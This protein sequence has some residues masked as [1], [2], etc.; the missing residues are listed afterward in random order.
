MGERLP[1]PTPTSM[2]THLDSVI[3]QKLKAFARRRRSL[4]I[5]RGGLT[6]AAVLIAAMLL[7]AA[8]DYYVPFLPDAV[9]W[10]LSFT[11]YA[12]SFAVAWCYCLRPLLHAPTERQMAR[13][14][15][16]AEPKLR[17]D[18]LSAVELG[19]TRGGV[20]DSEQFRKLLQQDVS[21]RMQDIEVESLLPV[22]LIKRYIQVAAGIAAAVVALMF[23][24]QM[25]LSTLLLRAFAPGA[26]VA[27]V[28]NTRIIVVE[29][30]AGDRVVAQG[31]VVSLKIRLEG[32]V[33]GK[34]SLEAVPAGEVRAISEMK[35]VGRNEFT[36]TIKVGRGNVTYRVQAGDGLTRSYVLSAAARPI[37]TAFEKTYHYPV[38]S[39]Q[40]V[41][42]VTEPGGKLSAL[43]GTEVE[44]KITTN[45]PVKKGEL[46]LDVGSTK[47]T[48]PLVVLPD[49]RLTA[50]VPIK[51][52]GTYR[53]HLTSAETGFDNKFSPEYELRSEPDLL[54]AITLVEPE[55][56]LIS[57][58]NELV[59]VIAT[60]S[61]DVGL[62]QVAQMIK[63][64]DG[65]WKEVV[66]QKNAGREKRIVRDWDMFEEG[67]K[68]GDL[69][70]TKLVATDFAGHQ[71]DSRTLQ[72]TVVAAG[73]EMK[74]LGSL[75]NCEALLAALNALVAATDAVEK[76]GGLADEKFDETEADAP[77]GKKMLGGLAK[78]YEEFEAKL[79]ETWLA[80]NIPLRE[81]PANHQSADLVLL[82][83]M[84]VQ[85]NSAEAQ[86][87][88]PV[89][90]LLTAKPD[91]LGAPNLMRQ[92]VTAVTRLKALARIAQETTHLTLA[93]EELDVAA[94]LGLVLGAEQKRIIEKARTAKTPE[95]W[96]KLDT[97]FRTVLSTSKN[98]EGVLDQLATRGT[99][100]GDA[101]RRLADTLIHERETIEP[102]LEAG[103][104]D[105]ALLPLLERYEAALRTHTAKSFE[106]RTEL[107]PKLITTRLRLP[108]EP[109]KM[110]PGLVAV[111]H[112]DLME[113]L[114][115]IAMNIA[116]LRQ[117][118]AAIGKMSALSAEE[119]AALVLAGWNSRADIFKTH[120]DLE[121]F[122]AVADTA[123]VGDL[124]RATVALPLL[125]TLPAA[126][127]EAT[128]EEMNQSL[129]I[130]A[131]GHSLQELT[132]GLMGLAARER[133]E[134]RAPQ[135]RTGAA[136]DWAWIATR[137]HLAPE[138][139]K[140]LDLKDQAARAA[141]ESVA[142]LLTDM[143]GSAPFLKAAA[144]MATRGKLDRAPQSV[145]GEVEMLA[146]KL[147]MMLAVLRQP[148]DAARRDLGKL[149]P[150]ISE[151][152]LA[153]AKEEA[154]LKT[155]TAG[156]AEQALQAT[157]EANRTR[158]APQIAEQHQINL[159][160][161]TL[162]DLIRADANEQNILKKDQRERMR[163]ANDAIALLK[164]PPPRAQQALVDAASAEEVSQ[165]KTNL[166]TA[167]EQERLL[168]ERLTLIA[169]NYAA[170]EKGEVAA[171]TRTA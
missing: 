88:R 47:K 33:V 156:Q 53:L 8:L 49:G 97:R 31:D 99:P 12:A 149:A 96:A 78:A 131:G 23:L 106:A 9:R 147:R 72:I 64:N 116:R 153:L 32:A 107:A 63:V 1:N 154:A 120:G 151:L 136:R 171:D 113:E 86:K 111:T 56:D 30:E 51:A 69:V 155:V 22:A 43:E 90:D 166:E 124:R 84:L 36:A 21:H 41:K 101:A 105:K 163:D 118:L 85:I 54:P 40:E 73:F 115:P 130:L 68:E 80:L 3:H 34:A 119:R 98:I 108:A 100:A 14:L 45:Q 87:A 159:R 27:R 160:I 117:D 4:I 35:P 10:I 62:A 71:R 114:D 61:D 94:E 103:P 79:S 48:I 16:H 77:N 67:V 125:R 132:D 123:F 39:G 126:E 46:L 50:R 70:M 164:E 28:S 110:P 167:V 104:A 89:L 17:E 26:N 58:A 150:K 25:R 158:T 24:S 76:E 129:R 20:F 15:E 144:E 65:A 143:N 75:R 2:S 135:A 165:Q 11:A 13:L 102:I 157:P 137:T 82:G 169:K 18:L 161:E 38:Y 146:G 121:E 60:A 92:V 142:N 52:T 152:A 81:V 6:S 168:V 140:N 109:V 127:S 91:S 37:E 93:G 95:A 148:M 57:P 128:L 66:L 139:L 145:R 29:P 44:L 7:V 83:Q 59:K 162:K 42:T 138:Q 141:V 55:N 5:L 170:L 133:W 19:S 122:R 112:R 74:R 134:L